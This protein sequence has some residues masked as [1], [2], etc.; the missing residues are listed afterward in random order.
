MTTDQR[1][2]TVEAWV[3]AKARELGAPIPVGER[4]SEQ[5]D[6]LITTAQGMIGIELSEVLRPAREGGLEP[7]KAAS[8]HAEIVQIAE[9]R[10][11]RSDAA[12]PLRMHVYFTND[13]RI[14]KRQVA[15]ALV[16]CVIAHRDREDVVTLAGQ[17]V[18]EGIS[19]IVFWRDQQ[20]RWLNVEHGTVSVSQVF[21]QIRDRITAKNRLVPIYCANLPPGSQIWLLLWSTATVSRG[22]PI[23]YGLDKWIVPFGF[24]RV[25]FFSWLDAKIIELPRQTT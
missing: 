12:A 11:S 23:P 21:D 5:P 14:D 13:G 3:I 15:Y 24:E 6:F 7:V 1:R 19:R 10:Y 20:S 9:E 8:V 17:Q 16:D 2:K 22:L 4:S 18:P 25:F